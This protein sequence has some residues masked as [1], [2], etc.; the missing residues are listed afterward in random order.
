M[1]E[2]LTSHRP[3][4][5][6]SIKEEPQRNETACQFFRVHNGSHNRKAG[7]KTVLKLEQLD[8]SFHFWRNAES[9][10]DD[11]IIRDRGPTSSIRLEISGKLSCLKTLY[12]AVGNASQLQ[13]S[14]ELSRNWLLKE[15]LPPQNYFNTYINV[16]CN[17]VD[18][19]LSDVSMWYPSR[20]Q[21]PETIQ[22]TC[23]PRALSFTN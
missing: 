19:S 13:V 6:V 10:I 18:R 5:N 15:Q 7:R 8:L 16:L 20:D 1:R 22:I 21:E 4:K 17:K 9:A 11:K 23:C 2:T 12:R 3:R 14:A